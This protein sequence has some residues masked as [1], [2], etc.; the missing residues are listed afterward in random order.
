M[1]DSNYDKLKVYE[2][3]DALHAL[4]DKMTQAAE[5]CRM[6]TAEIVARNEVRQLEHMWTLDKRSN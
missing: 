4:A 3:Y 5:E 6:Q 2:L 1:E